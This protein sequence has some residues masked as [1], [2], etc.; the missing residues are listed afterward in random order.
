MFVRTI[1]GER[2]VGSYP[3]ATPAEALGYFA[4]KYDEAVA[5]VELFEQRLAT[6]NLTASEISSAVDGLREM[7]RNLRAVGDLE[8]LTAR[9]EAL[10]PAAARKREDAEAARRSAR[11]QTRA[12]RESLV[13]EAEE[14]AAKPAEHITWRPDGQ[15]MKDLFD[16]W[17]TEQALPSARLDRRAEDALWKRFSHARS[18]FDR[19]RR[20]HFAQLDGQQA[21]AK[22]AKN[23]LVAEAEALQGSRDWGPTT[24]AYKRLMD[25]WRTAG[26]AARKDDDALWRRFKAAQDTFFAARGASLAKQDQE[27]ATNLAAKE[28]LLVRAE[29]LLPVTDLQTAKVTLREIQDRW[30]VIGKVPRG[31]LDRIERRMRTV[32]QA[33]R[34]HEDDRWRRTNPE[35]QARARSAVEQLESGIADLEHQLRQANERGQSAR[36]AELQAAV[37]ARREWLEQA[38]RALTDFGG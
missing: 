18:L 27:F 23:V 16:A 5:Q 9:V 36:V 8:A 3:G 26:R 32:E 1:D 33:V 17:R 34:S 35:A 11:E 22:R 6:T 25:R 10:A 7:V 30:E 20:Q 24:A 15:R 21:E 12:R 2:E 28:D 31:D 38:R 4:R 19:K 29:A 14:L 37:T 13:K